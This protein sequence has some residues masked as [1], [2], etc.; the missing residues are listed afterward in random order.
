MWCRKAAAQGEVMAQVHLGVMYAEGYAVTQDYA[1]AMMWFRKAAAQG[2]AIAQYNLGTMYADARSVPQD[3]VQAMMWY[4]IAKD[5]GI[6]LDDQNL[7]Q[8]KAHSTWG[9]IAEAN[10]M[11]QEWWTAHPQKS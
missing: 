2:A 11:A 3:N 4:L 9:Q 10:K 6:E 8:L 7:Q 1:Q 5:G